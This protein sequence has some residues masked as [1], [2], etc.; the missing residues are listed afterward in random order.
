MYVIAIDVKKD[1]VL[2]VSMEDISNDLEGGKR[3]DNVMIK[4]QSQI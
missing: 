4:I 2:K 3:K 1:H